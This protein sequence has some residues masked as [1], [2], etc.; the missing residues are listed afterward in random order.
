MTLSEEDAQLFY[1][2]FFPLLDY[3][4]EKRQ[5]DDSLV[6][7]AHATSLNPDDVI[8]V[9][10]NLWDDPSIIDDYL[11]NHPLDQEGREIVD[12]WKR[13]KHDKFLIERILKR[14]AMFIGMDNE[15]YKVIGTISEFEDIFYYHPK[16]ILLETCLL[17]FKGQ[18]IT[19]GLFLPYPV[20]I[21]P[22]VRGDFKDIY[23]DAK[24]HGRIIES[25]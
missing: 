11:K 16:P 20:T 12:S 17:P 3:V 23:M 10:H 22:H 8:K 14:G 24:R 13:C 5:I 9:A 25:F 6:D 1:K 15:V 18:I 2:L 7:M 4:N 21:G 19:D